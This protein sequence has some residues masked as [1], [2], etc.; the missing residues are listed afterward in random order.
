M[1]KSKKKSTFDSVLKINGIPSV[2]DQPSKESGPRPRKTVLDPQGQ[3]LPTWNKIFVLSCVISIALDPLFFYIL[4]IDDKDKC[5]DLDET[6][7]IIACVL[8]SLFDVFYI[9]HISLQFR[10]AFIAP[11]RVFGRGV[12][13]NDPV[14][15]A[16]IYLSTYFLI[17][18]LSILPL[19]QVCM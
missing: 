18:I 14:A 1:E 10:A 11:S 19:P 8:H 15:I 12:L 16:K 2:G 13:I 3:D 5:L 7:M 4:V 9:L 6:L 17:D